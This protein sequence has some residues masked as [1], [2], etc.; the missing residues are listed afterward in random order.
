MR[1]QRH[2]LVFIAIALCAA[3]AAHAQQTVTTTW[4]GDAEIAYDTGFMHMLM[5]HPSGGV[6][7]FDM[8]LVQ[9]DA[10][11]AG[12]SEK[13]PSSDTVWGPNRARKVFMLDDPRAEK[14]YL[15]VFLYRQGS[16]PLEF[17]VNGNA[18]RPDN[19]DQ[20]ANPEMYRWVEFP[21]SWLEE[22]RNTVDLFC[23]R[24]GSE[25]EGW[26]FYIARA[27]EFAGGGGDPAPVGET[28]F[29]ST[30]GG[31][32][33]K[34]S[35]FG[36]LGGTRAEY[37]IRLSLDRHVAEGWLATPVIDLWKGGSEDLIVPLREIRTMK[38][39]VRADVP[40]GTDV[41]YFFRRGL[42]PDPFAE[43]WEPYRLVGEGETLDFEI[44]GADL[45]RRYVQI[46][47]ELETDNPL[48]S[49]VIERLTVDAGLLERVPLHDNI[50]VVKADN[51]PVA[52]SSLDWEWEK[53][54][55]PEFR[56]LLERENIAEV[57][58]G[59]RTDFDAQVKILD[60]V[61]KKWKWTLPRHNFPAW[62]ALSVLERVDNLGAGGNC[63]T[64]NNT[65][66]G[67]CMAL[68]WQARLINCVGHEVIEVWNDD[69]G[70]WVVLDGSFDPDNENTYQYDAETAE[71]LNMLE[72]HRMYLDYY[73]PGQ[74]IDWMKDYTHYQT[75][76]EDKPSP[77]RRGSLTQE[78]PSRD[79]GFICAAFMRLVPRNNWY[80]KPHPR[81]LNHGSTWW[82][83]DGYV[84]WY[85]DQ[86]PPKRQ[87]SHHTD[88]PR[89]MWPDLNTVKVDAVSGFGND[90]LFLRFETYT[91][92]FSHYEIDV[93]DTG[94]E[95]LS[96]ERW[97][98]L[99][100]SGRN[101]LRVRA[102]NKLGAQGKPTVI[103]LNHAD[104][105]FG[106]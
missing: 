75:I 11:G 79:T 52:Y 78:K 84:N 57:I 104:A 54:D 47:A 3:A 7:L 101:T 5:K 76:L 42:S 59:S 99:L 43:D 81:P 73:F 31:E 28:S 70:K 87:Y 33:W 17:T 106:K 82:P 80:E 69:Y 23:P 36:P 93:D 105:P 19:W 26:M 48:E 62:D 6:S 64:V 58:A 4:G 90:R 27:D 51:P 94:W 1:F 55:R 14:A 10:P 40:A 16:H 24:A 77:V 18:S 60:Y 8:D 67:I 25:E 2:A 12:R 72:M 30:D 37:S 66:G 29:K 63:I 89:D 98:W 53:W 97:T 61:A 50:H 92:N 13:G 9:N 46:R 49:P 95:Q 102:V 74:T 88:R 15:V 91:P 100:Q 83:W 35:P 96:G 41:R 44:G 86:T 32:T 20:E 22:G 45:N 65:I 103:K 85:D 71:P 38:L 34:E 68:G 21:A 39:S 56:E